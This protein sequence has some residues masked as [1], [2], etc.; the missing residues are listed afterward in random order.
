MLNS[1]NLF[2]KKEEEF[3][4]SLAVV[5]RHPNIT[6]VHLEA[7]HDS[8]EEFVDTMDWLEMKPLV[9][10]LTILEFNSLYCDCCINELLPFGSDLKILSFESAFGAVDRLLLAISTLTKLETL[11]LKV[12]D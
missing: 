8:G 5:G 9:S 4:T 1:M 2:T 10:R 11:R 3:K 6:E 12:Q 7:V